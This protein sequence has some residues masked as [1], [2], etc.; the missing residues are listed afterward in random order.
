VTSEGR[1]TVEEVKSDATDPNA[2]DSIVILG[3]GKKTENEITQDSF[4]YTDAISEFIESTTRGSNGLDNNETAEETSLPMARLRDMNAGTLG[5]LVSG[6]LLKSTPFG[7][8][9]K[10]KSTAL[11]S[12]AGVSTNRAKRARRAS[13]TSKTTTKLPTDKRLDQSIEDVMKLVSKTNGK[14]SSKELDNLTIDTLNERNS[15]KEILT[16]FELTGEG[17][18]TSTSCFL[19]TDICQLLFMWEVPT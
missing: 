14:F 5:Y 11:G 1:F 18:P 8:R 4:I 16:L 3:S 15:L 19:D 17:T 6:G 2:D 13:D 10:V 12:A 9:E 7:I